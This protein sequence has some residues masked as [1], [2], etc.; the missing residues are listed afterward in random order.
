MNGLKINMHICFA[1]FARCKDLS[2]EQ[3]EKIIDNVKLSGKVSAMKL[4]PDKIF[5]DS[6]M[7]GISIDS[8]DEKIW[9]RRADATAP[10]NFFLRRN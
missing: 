1:H 6:D 5:S 10:A 4:A 3:W 7:P 9:S 2:L 8:F